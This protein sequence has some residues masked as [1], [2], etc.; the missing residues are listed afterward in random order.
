MG[1]WGY[2]VVGWVRWPVAASST[3]L[4]SAP[5]TSVA[6]PL[7]QI[8]L[9]SEGSEEIFQQYFVTLLMRA[10]KNLP[11]VGLLYL[12]PILCNISILNNWMKILIV[13]NKQCKKCT[14]ICLQCTLNWSSNKCPFKWQWSE[15][16]KI[17]N[18]IQKLNW[19]HRWRN[20]MVIVLIRIIDPQS[21]FLCKEGRIKRKKD[22]KI[23]ELR[24]NFKQ[25]TTLSFELNFKDIFIA[26]L[27]F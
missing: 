25:T 27:T 21:N 16:C 6:L 4:S 22:K 17:W 11:L 3:L 18:L 5:T 1:G 19:V 24:W 10:L 20:G 15:K 26:D 23:Y 2:Y 9:C 7:P 14:Q 12:F 8:K 13:F